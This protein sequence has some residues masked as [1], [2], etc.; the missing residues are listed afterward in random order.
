MAQ[1]EEV[2]NQVNQLQLVHTLTRA[3][4]KKE[5]ETKQ[6]DEE[7]T[8]ESQANIS[9]WDEVEILDTSQ[10]QDDDSQ[11]EDPG[12]LRAPRG[13]RDRKEMGQAQGRDDSLQELRQMADQTD[14]P[15]TI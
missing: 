3:Q 12:V 10:E 2:T 14:S 9:S 4:A 6:A 15:Y 5:R 11:N 1:E 7:A 13:P 8:K